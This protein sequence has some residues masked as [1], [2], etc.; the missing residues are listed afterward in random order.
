MYMYTYSTIFVYT[1]TEKLTAVT[2]A[3]VVFQDI[4]PGTSAIFME[5]TQVVAV[6]APCDYG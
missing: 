6:L 5:F 3:F 1:V 2:L 4:E